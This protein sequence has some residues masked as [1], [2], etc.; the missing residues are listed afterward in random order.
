MGFELKKSQLAEPSRRCI[1]IHLGDPMNIWKPWAVLS[2]VQNTCSSR[3]R[4]QSVMCSSSAHGDFWS[5][6]MSPQNPTPSTHSPPSSHF[7]HSLLLG[8]A[9][10][11]SHSAP[12]VFTSL[13]SLPTS[14]LTAHSLRTPVCP[15]LAVLFNWLE[16]LKKSLL[17]LVLLA[18]FTIMINH[19]RA[20]EH[21]TSKHCL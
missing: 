9:P 19:F 4:I 14:A 7:S 21:Y 8:S 16:L 20:T 18:L 3:G 11:T 10:V 13:C 2:S 5:P 15:H 6:T 17:W 1:F 12:R